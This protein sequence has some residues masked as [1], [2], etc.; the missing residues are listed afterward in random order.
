MMGEQVTFRCN[1]HDDRRF[2][3]DRHAYL[4]FYSASLLNQQSTGKL[5]APLGHIIMIPRQLVF[6]PIS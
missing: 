5:I 4:D 2:V 1:V 3:K 6:A